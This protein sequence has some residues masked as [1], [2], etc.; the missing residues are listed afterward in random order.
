M[1]RNK[2]NLDDL[3]IL[4]ISPSQIS[5]DNLVTFQKTCGMDKSIFRQELV[6]YQAIAAT[7]L[8]KLETCSFINS[9]LLLGAK[10]LFTY[11]ARM[12]YVFCP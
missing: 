2:G 6:K 12:T 9:M 8:D 11:S 4:I 10:Y 5:H 1:F 3:F 7:Q